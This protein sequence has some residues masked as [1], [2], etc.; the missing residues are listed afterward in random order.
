M[1]HKK[2]PFYL[3]TYSKCRTKLMLQHVKLLIKEISE[4]NLL[5]L[6]VFLFLVSTL[7]LLACGEENRLRTVQNKSCS[8]P[9]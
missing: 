6:M 7:G 8:L 4:M 9:G 1:K 3:L 2:V 5:V